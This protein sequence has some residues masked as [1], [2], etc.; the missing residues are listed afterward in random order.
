MPK[1][2][3]VVGKGFEKHPERINRKGRPKKLVSHINSQLKEEGFKEV[4]KD[5][6][7]TA[8]LTIIN[9]PISKIKKIAD[10]KND[11]YPFLYKLVAKELGGKRGADMLE[12]LL[13]RSLGKST[14][15]VEQKNEE[16][17]EKV[18]RPKRK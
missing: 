1:P 18:I 14:Q 7:K 12:N 4:S 3:N 15:V 11:D 13:D 16:V 9:L 8:Y 5:D 10:P 2:E 6:V 17:T